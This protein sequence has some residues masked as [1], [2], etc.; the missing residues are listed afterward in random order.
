V[1]VGKRCRWGCRPAARSRELPV[2]RAFGCRPCAFGARRLARSTHPAHE[3]GA[4]CSATCGAAPGADLS[5]E[6]A[7]I[8]PEPLQPALSLGARRPTWSGERIRCPSG[9]KPAGT[10]AR[11]LIFLMREGKARGADP[12]EH[13]Q[14]RRLPCARPS[15]PG[16]TQRLPARV[17]RSGRRARAAGGTSVGRPRLW[18]TTRTAVGQALVET[19]SQYIV[20]IRGLARAQGV[21]LPTCAAHNFVDRMSA[22]KLD[23]STRAL[24]AP[25]ATVLESVEEQ[26]AHVDD[27]LELVAKR[28]PLLQLCATVPGVGSSSLQRFWRLSM[29]R[30]ASRMPMPSA[31]I[32][33]S[34]L[35][36][37][38][39]VVRPSGVWARL[40]SRAT[41][42]PAPCSCRLHGAYCGEHAN[43]TIPCAYG[44]LALPNV[45]GACVA[46]VAVARRLAGVLWAMCRDGT[47]YS[48]ADQAQASSAGVRH[49]VQDD[50][51]H[52]AALE[53]C[54]RRWSPPT[55]IARVVNCV[56]ILRFVPE[57]APRE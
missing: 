29:T 32:W 50:K 19:R 54:R 53:E 15:P 22:A 7:R 51:A 55:R 39:P 23:A 36:S 57:A 17:A 52:A 34:F 11:D 40:P 27:E 12:G 46:A 9:R 41:H 38:R 44:A 1:P 13:S 18:S 4:T 47:F 42:T 26:L 5:P 49:R 37:R 30:N 2:L 6:G 45:V 10:G 56:S 24:V 16:A 25:L 33:G 35:R 20:T 31:R 28:D 14:D 8:E 43:P 48:P 21:L 3:R